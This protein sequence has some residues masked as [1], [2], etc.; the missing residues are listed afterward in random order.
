MAADQGQDHRA[1]APR[2]PQGID[3]AGLVGAEGWWRLVP[4]VRERFSEEPG[5]GR[6][7]R[8]TGLMQR[9]ES[10]L[11]G[12]LLAQLCRLLGTPFAPHLGRDV[13]VVITLRHRGA[14]T[15]EWEREYR[16]RGRAPVCVASIKRVDADGCLSECVGCGLGMRLAVFEAG[17]ALHFLSLQYFWT[18]GRHRIVLPTWL[19]PG[20]AH[21]VHADLG[22][23]RFRFTLSFHHRLF[24]RLF[25]QDGVFQRE[26]GDAP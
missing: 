14:H 12:W 15:V 20:T 19:T 10:S 8:Y 6:P 2:P 23:G 21:V 1:P 18:L 22:A 17:R 24:G 26:E 9:V 25:H 3:F 5:P 4:A 7:L 16:Y 13:P 11:L